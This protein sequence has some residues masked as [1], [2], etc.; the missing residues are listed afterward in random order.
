MAIRVSEGIW[1]SRVLVE[2][3]ENVIPHIGDRVQLVRASCWQEVAF[4]A[5]LAKRAF[6][7]ST[8]HAKTLGGE[9]LL[10]LSGGLQIRDAIRERGV[11][12]GDNYLVVFGD[13]ATLEEFIKEHG[14]KEVKVTSCSPAD[15]KTFF[16][17]SALVEVL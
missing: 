5:I 7:R 14:L 2:N 15:M 16:E 17:K 1:I 13:K 12:K 9:L 11:I 3:P 4:A 8:N 10:R 6:E